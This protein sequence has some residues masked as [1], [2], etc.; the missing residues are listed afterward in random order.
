MR[1]HS[2]RLWAAL[3]LLIS[4][5]AAMFGFLLFVGLMAVIARIILLLCAVLLTA[6]TIRHYL[7][8]FR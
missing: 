5:V 6:F 4:A 1:Q 2:Y 8:R 3:F 7:H